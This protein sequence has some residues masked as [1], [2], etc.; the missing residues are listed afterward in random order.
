MSPVPLLDL[1]AQ[2][3]S[4]ES[5]INAAVLAVLRDQRFILGP[6]VE[7]LET[8][9]SAYVGA[10]YGVG[11][12]SGSDALLMAI[13]ALDLGPGDEVITTCYSFFATAGSIVRAGARPV[14]VD[15][16]PA[17]FNLDPAQVAARLSP[18]TRAIMPVHLFGRAA[19]M[20]ALEHAAPGVPLIEDAAQA[21]GSELEG[22]RVG[23]LGRLACFSFFP[24]KNLGGYG[25]GGLITTNDRA[26]ADKLRALRIHGQQKSGQYLHSMVGGNFRLDALQAA[27][28]RVKLQHLESWTA[29][30]RRHAARYRELLG[31]TGLE[32]RLPPEDSFGCRDVYN[33]F[34]IRVPRRD[35]LAA[36]LTS[37]KIGSAVYYPR[38]LHL[39]PCFAE[40]GYREGD[41]PNAEAASRESLA[42][43][44]YPELEDAQICE[45]VDRIVEFLRS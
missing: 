27:V 3:R 13:M 5:E 15:I 21:I 30:R 8:E 44:V 18:R 26:L 2:Y 19:A 33:Q 17:T 45:V 32:I 43:P 28:L 31:Q 12:S 37:H 16:D 24:S 29:A 9:M 22:R 25:D 39:Q 1:K 6:E 40:L 34:V 10:Q 4:I 20:Q 7:A 36:H 38:G 41:F 23:A 35:A 14:L 42:I 11:V